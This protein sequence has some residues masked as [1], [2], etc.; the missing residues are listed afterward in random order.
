MRIDL[1]KRYLETSSNRLNLTER[2]LAGDFNLDSAEIRKDEE[3]ANETH[4]SISK[5]DYDLISTYLAVLSNQIK[6]LEKYLKN[7]KQK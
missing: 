6:S 4:S 2:H 3:I 7:L 1:V 5:L